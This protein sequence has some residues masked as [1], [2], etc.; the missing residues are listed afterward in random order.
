MGVEQHLVGL[1][2]V[3]PQEKRAAVGQLEVRD[4]QLGP[5][6]G[7]DRPV[8]RPIELERLAGR[9]ASGTN[10]PRPHVCCSCCR[11]AFQ[12]RAKAAT[13]LYEPS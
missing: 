10:T 1:Q 9:N 4:L 11:A 7:K 2:R 3:G 5:L 8:F 13:R 6:A 12:S